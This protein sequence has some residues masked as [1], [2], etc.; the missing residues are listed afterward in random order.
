[1]EGISVLFPRLKERSEIMEKKNLQTPILVAV[2]L[3]LLT[4]YLITP[5]LKIYSIWSLLNYVQLAAFGIIIYC[6]IK[7]RRDIVLS[8]GFCLLALV[9]F[10]TFLRGFATHTYDVYNWW[11][12]NY[13]FNLFCFLPAVA[14]LFAVVGAALVCASKATEL[15][16]QYRDMAEKY[17]FIPAGLHIAKLL[18]SILV[19]LGMAVTGG[20]WHGYRFTF[21]GLVLS[22]AYAAAVLITL[23]WVVT[24]DASIDPA[25]LKKMTGSTASAKSGD[26]PVVLDDMFCSIG[27]HVLLLLFTLGIWIL[28]WIYRVTGYTNNMK[29][30]EDRSP[31][32]QLLLCMFVPFYQIFWT[33]KTAQRIDMMAQNKGLTSDITTLCLILEI[34]VP[35]VPPIIMQDKLNSIVTTNGYAQPVSKPAPAA[36]SAPVYEA[37]AYTAP[38]QQPAPAKTEMGLADELRKYKELLDMGAITQEEFDAMKKKLLGL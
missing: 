19:T 18:L 2:G 34:F 27:K 26:G 15:V 12:G 20:R 1:M 3:F 16:P 21:S 11:S 31:A 8:A 25:A 13:R 28:I 23:K 22:F 5:T 37:P 29:G 4:A 7:E 38:V 36:Y 10:V 24:G 14:N 30:E 17:W 35:V 33:Y 32:N 9:T 6:L